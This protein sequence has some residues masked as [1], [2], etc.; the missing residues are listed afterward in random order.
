MKDKTLKLM[1]AS[2]H[3]VISTIGPDG[4]PQS[5]LVGF[6]EDEELNLV[7]GTYKNSRKFSNIKGDSKVA[8]V[9]ASEENK[10]E[11]QYEGHAKIVDAEE[12]GDR[13]GFHFKK[14]PAAEKRQQDPN[15]AWIKVTPSWVRFVDANYSPV[16]YEETSFR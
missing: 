13:L 4:E 5:A 2:K 14:L 10:L 12:L 16:K 7:I 9:I 11:I 15:Q 1:A 6:S 3:C 8:V